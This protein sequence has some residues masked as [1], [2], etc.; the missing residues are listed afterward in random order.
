MQSLATEILHEV[1]K[2]AT[3]WQIATAITTVIAIAEFM[4]IVFQKG[5]GTKTYGK[6]KNH[7]QFGQYYRRI[8]KH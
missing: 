6:R 4:I 3:F 2:K 8:Q 1:K 7:K 5:K